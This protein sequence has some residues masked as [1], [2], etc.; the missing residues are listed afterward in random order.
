MVAVNIDQQ[1]LFLLKQT[2]G[3]LKLISTD[4]GDYTP[5]SGL[6]GASSLTYDVVGKIVEYS[7]YTKGGN[8]LIQ[9]GD[10]KAIIAAKGLHYVPKPQDI[11][12]DGAVSYKVV[13]VRMMKDRN[14]VVAYV[15]QIRK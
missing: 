12:K 7:D 10:R 1:I 13:N 3:K 5:G 6:S 8:N 14:S 11:L 9:G 15:C 4:A 2:Q